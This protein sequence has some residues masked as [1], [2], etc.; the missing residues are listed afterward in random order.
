MNLN[1]SDYFFNSIYILILIISVQ[2][3]L[4]FLYKKKKY[5][6]SIEGNIGTGKTTFLNKL[7][8]KINDSVF[9]KEPVD[10]WLGL[11][12][13]SGE[14]ILEKFYKNPK[15]W[16]YTFQNLAFITR[17]NSILDEYY[18]TDKKFIFSDRI[19]VSDR[20]IFATMSKEDGLMDEI[21]WNIYNFWYNNE[22]INKLVENK[23]YYIYLK[24]DPETCLK[25]INKRNRSEEINITLDYLN[26][27]HN[28]HEKWLTDNKKNVLILDNNSDYFKD[29]KILEQ[30][31]KKV[32]DFLT[33]IN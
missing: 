26:K 33:D 13:N 28:L 6:I 22:F 20:K 18:E 31:I 25:R 29:E 4:S 30:K 24:S 12:D 16:C 14:N 23:I 11:K 10:I 7:K 2:N 27:L 21:E 17:L 19:T 5:I 3:I 15:R 8:E 1:I 32:K 9:I